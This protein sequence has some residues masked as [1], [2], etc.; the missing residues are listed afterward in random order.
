MYAAFDSLIR[1]KNIFRNKRIPSEGEGSK[2]LSTF[3]IKHF[4]FSNFHAQNHTNFIVFE[5]STLTRF[6]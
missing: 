5:L 4:S 2:K 1:K 6:I 3:L